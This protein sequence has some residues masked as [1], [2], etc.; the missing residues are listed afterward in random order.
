MKRFLSFVG[1]FS[2]LGAGCYSAPISTSSLPVPQAALPVESVLPD[3]SSAP[4]GLV[5]VALSNTDTVPE[6]PAPPAPQQ[7]ALFISMTSGNFFFDPS[8]ITASPGQTVTISFVD[9]EG[10][11]TF[12]IDELGIQKDVTTGTVITFAAPE[13]PGNYAYYCDTGAHRKLGMEGILTVK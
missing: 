2:I 10:S 6:N 1:I 11:H 9:S 3:V 13:T 7:E 4:S 12:V 5:D 8:A